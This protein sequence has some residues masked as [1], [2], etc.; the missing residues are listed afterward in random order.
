MSA[1]HGIFP[2]LYAFF[3]EANA[4]DRQAF[5]QQVEVCIASGAHGIALLGLITEVKTLTPTERETL[6]QWAVEDIAGRVPLMA[7]IAGATLDEVGALAAS[8]EAA[9]ANYLILQPPLGQKP[10]S[11]DLLEFYSSAMGKITAEVGI[12]N[13][14]EYL[15]VGLSPDE[16]KALRR[17]HANFTLMKGEGPMI[18]VKPFIDALGSDFVIFN[19][20]GGLELPDNLLAGCAGMIPAPDCA[21]VQITIYEAVKAGDLETAQR[22]YG[23]ALPY[24]V[25]AMQSLDVAILYGKTMFARRAGIANA[26]ACRAPTIMR[27]PFFE[28]ALDRWSAALGPYGR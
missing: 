6:V 24:I 12:Q 21:D 25:Y 22:L 13:A 23:L 2:M 16:V 1:P 14:P 27:E 20:R 7:T 5:R 9:G 28:A 17:R 26:G 4:L 8:A 15:G 3:D 10:A 11:A 19:G 18:Q